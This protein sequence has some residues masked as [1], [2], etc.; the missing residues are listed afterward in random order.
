MLAIL[1][2]AKFH[3]NPLE[4]FGK[5]RETYGDGFLAPGARVSNP[6]EAVSLGIALMFGTAGLPHILMRFYTVPGARAARTSVF[7]ATG[8]IGYFYL[9]AQMVG[10]GNLIR[11]MFGLDYELAVV[12]VGVVMLAYVSF[13]G[14]IATTSEKV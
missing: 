12:I 6:L 7:Y 8:L 4:L 9:I 5:A 11:L 1:V 14:M 2:L 13:G 3:F 10:A